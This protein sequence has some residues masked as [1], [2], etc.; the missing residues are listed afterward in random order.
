M[1]YYYHLTDK[2]SAKEILSQ[3]LHPKIGKNSR[4]VGETEKAVYLASRGDVPFWK[5]ILNQPVILKIDRTY[6]NELELLQYCYG[7]YSEY[8][9]NHSIPKEAISI[10]HIST[11]LTFE[12]MKKLCISY[13]DDASCICI[14]FAKYIAYLHTKHDYAIANYEK[15]Q[16]SI[17][18]ARP[19]YEQLDMTS[20]DT[21]ELITHLKALGEYGRYTLCDRYDYNNPDDDPNRPRLWEMLNK[22][23]FATD[24]TK[25]LYNWLKQNLSEL[26]LNAETG[27]WTG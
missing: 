23:G 2:N 8:K 5:I 18:A 22:D 24:E 7:L 26:A 17:K 6:L 14:A 12:Q 13:I 10:A 3:G 1:K 11:K 9:Y 16:N 27:G 21:T 19:A 15:V 4:V 25:W 20:V